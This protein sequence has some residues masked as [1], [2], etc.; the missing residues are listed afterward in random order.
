MTFQSKCDNH[1]YSRFSEPKGNK[2][3]APELGWAG[4]VCV[5]PEPQG[6]QDGVPPPFHIL[7][8]LLHSG[9][10]SQDFSP[11]PAQNPRIHNIDFELDFQYF[12]SKIKISISPAIQLFVFYNLQLAFKWSRFLCKLVNGSRRCK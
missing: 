4:Q 1:F 8:P 9:H 7:S 10:A 12:V 2:Q 5:R 11:N 6:L 3:I